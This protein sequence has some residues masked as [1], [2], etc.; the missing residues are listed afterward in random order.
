M[1]IALYFVYSKE[2]WLSIVVPLF[3]VAILYHNI[4]V[5]SISFLYKIYL[6]I[7][8][9]IVHFIQKRGALMPKSEAQ[10]KAD[11]KYRYKKLKDGT[12]KQI[13]A[14]LNISDY[15]Y[16][17]NYCKNNNISKARL[18]VSACRYCIENNIDLNT[19]L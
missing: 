1:D 12:K 11:K 16:I 8:V 10:K 4:T 19:F 15:D 18:I 3:T 2:C 7:R 13:N 6:N 5:L 9:F 14:T 17:D